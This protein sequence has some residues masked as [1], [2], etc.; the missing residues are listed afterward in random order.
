MIGLAASAGSLGKRTAGGPA[1]P[2]APRRGLGTMIAGAFAATA[3]A[4]AVLISTASSASAT[5]ETLT[6]TPNHGQ[7]TDSFTAIYEVSPPPAD[8]GSGAELVLFYWDAERAPGGGGDGPQGNEGQMHLSGDYC[9][10]SIVITPT[11]SDG[12][13]THQLRGDRAPY[14]GPVTVYGTASAYYTI[15][16][17]PSSVAPDSGSSPGQPHASGGGRPQAISSGSAGAASTAPPSAAVASSDTPLLPGPGFAIA[18]PA[19]RASRAVSASASKGRRHRDG[20][21]SGWWWIGVIGAAVA[22][23]AGSTV[24]GK[25]RR[26]SATRA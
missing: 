5:T 9:R 19:A 23:A 15:D 10:A 11:A 1:R 14:V 26:W 21:V 3:I 18:I 20:G 25:R 2:A 17:P 16:P 6:L 4:G 8:G 24:V 7:A 12:A 22:V 13:G